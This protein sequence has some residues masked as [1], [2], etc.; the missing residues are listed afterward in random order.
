[1][2]YRML[3]AAAALAIPAAAMAAP[4]TP[5]K[6]VMT[7][8]ASDLY[9]IESSKLVL[10]TTTNPQVRQFADGMIADHTKSTADVKAAAM[11]SGVKPMPPVLTP[12][13]AQMIAELRAEKGMARD[14]AYLAQQKASHQGALNVQKAYAM[15]G[16]AMPLKM[17]ASNIVPVVQMHID[18]L[19]K[20]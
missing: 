20:M 2:S 15:E 14:G 3:S 10:A 19:A 6:Y 12:M 11:K 18:M 1:M 9:E 7:A 8:G 5:A 16:T 13:Q 17:A 4:M